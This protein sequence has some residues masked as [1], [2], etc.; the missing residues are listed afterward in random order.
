MQPLNARAPR[1]YKEILTFLKI[2]TLKG[3][4]KFLTRTFPHKIINNE[5]NCSR[6]LENLSF[7][8]NNENTRGEK[9]FLIKNFTN[10]NCVGIHRS[11][12]Q[13]Q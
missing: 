11:Y 3:R 10:N 7:K 8:N 12:S 6:F 4:G 13:I 2:P 1:S 9:T 5:I